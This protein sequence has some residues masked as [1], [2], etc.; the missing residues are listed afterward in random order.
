MIVASVRTVHLGICLAAVLS[1]YGFF[2]TSGLP[3]T[4]GRG[5]F[6]NVSRTPPVDYKEEHNSTSTLLLLVP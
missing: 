6:W 1:K 2:V 5:V 4:Q 3:D